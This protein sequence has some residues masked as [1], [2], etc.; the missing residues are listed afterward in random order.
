MN[1]TLQAKYEEYLKI[2]PNN[3]IKHEIQKLYQAGEFE[4]L[5]IYLTTRLSFGTAGLRGRMGCGY[6][7]MN[8][9]V[10]IQTTQG[11]IPYLNQLQLQ[12]TKDKVFNAYH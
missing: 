6:C 8:D 11:L 7:R 5:N 12:N 4:K 1:S 2:D 9:I 10:I 3:D